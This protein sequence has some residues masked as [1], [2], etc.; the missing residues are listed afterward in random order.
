[1]GHMEIPRLGVEAE[2]QLPAYTIGAG[3]TDVFQEH[4]YNQRCRF[5][6]PWILNLLSRTRV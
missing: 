5:P 4:I 6:P 2:L 1:M 3:A